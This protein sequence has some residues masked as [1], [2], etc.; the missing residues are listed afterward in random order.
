MKKLAL[1][2]LLFSCL[3]GCAAFDVLSILL[4]PDEPYPI[5]DANSAGTEWDGKVCLK[6]SDGSYWWT[7]IPKH[8]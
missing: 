1:T 6:Y 3:S 5:C 4:L 2:V 8:N 7:K